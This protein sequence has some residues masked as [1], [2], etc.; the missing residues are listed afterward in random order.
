MILSQLVCP[1]WVGHVL[2]G[3]PAPSAQ[4]VD[5]LASGGMRVMEPNNVDALFGTTSRMRDF[6]NEDPSS[7]EEPVFANCQPRVQDDAVADG[8]QSPELF[9]N[10]IACDRDDAPEVEPAQAPA[11][12][13]TVSEEVSSLWRLFNEGVLS[14][15]EFDD[16]KATVIFEYKESVGGPCASSSVVKTKPEHVGVKREKRAAPSTPLFGGV[17][18]SSDEEGAKRIKLE[19]VDAEGP[20]GCAPTA[21]GT[22]GQTPAGR[23]EGAIAHVK[24]EQ[25]EPAAVTEG[26]HGEP[27]AVTEGQPQAAVIDLEED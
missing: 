20:Q 21:A 1:P 5:P 27:A 26:Q 11:Q 4:P 19:P 2:H 10:G 22:Q 18:D 17:V 15:A 24:Q 14:R 13:K 8:S 25:R 7:V 23:P 16:L 9:A 6:V 3:G 12:G